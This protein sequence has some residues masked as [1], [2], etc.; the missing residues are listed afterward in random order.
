MTTAKRFYTYAELIHR[1]TAQLIPIYNRLFNT[2][3]WDEVFN[4][5]TMQTLNDFT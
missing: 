1:S 5:I 2:N 3:I 4:P